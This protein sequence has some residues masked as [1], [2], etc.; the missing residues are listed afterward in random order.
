MRARINDEGQWVEPPPHVIVSSGGRLTAPQYGPLAQISMTQVVLPEPIPQPIARQ[1]AM[2]HLEIAP[3]EVA[4][5][6]VTQPATPAIE[7]AETSQSGAANDAAEKF[8]HSQP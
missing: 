5:L 6:A 7:S 8:P 4:E 3:R 1:P 2:L